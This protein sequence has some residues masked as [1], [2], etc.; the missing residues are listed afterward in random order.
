MVPQ[1]G[2]GLLTCPS[3]IPRSA[4]QRRSPSAGATV[5]YPIGPTG[6]S[7]LGMS[8]KLATLT[9]VTSLILTT[10]HTLSSVGTAISTDDVIQLPLP[11]IP[12][13]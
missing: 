11:A 6:T 9:P 13:L 7:N 12:A 10:P 2:E 8:E 3:V 1:E 4:W 5:R